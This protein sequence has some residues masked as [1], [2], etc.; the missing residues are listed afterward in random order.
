L[1]GAAILSI[2][3]CKDVLQPIEKC[4]FFLIDYHVLYEISDLVTYY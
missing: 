2:H 3:V 1:G 4:D